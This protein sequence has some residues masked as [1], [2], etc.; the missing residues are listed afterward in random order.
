MIQL[1]HRSVLILA[2]GAAFWLFSVEVAL[3]YIFL[4]LGLLL[5]D[6]IMLPLQKQLNLERKLPHHFEIDAPSPICWKVTGLSAW[7][8]NNIT[9]ED[10]FP[11]K[12]YCMPVTSE[13]MEDTYIPSV[14]GLFHLPSAALIIKGRLGLLSRR[15]HFDSGEEIK[16]FPKARSS[17][18]L[19]ST[20]FGKTNISA[21]RT[22]K[23]DQKG[24]E[25]ES[26]RPYIHGED[27]SNIEWK[28]SAKRGALIS[29]NWEME[30]DRHVAVLIDCGRKMAEKVGDRCILDYALDAV[31][32]LSRSIQHKQDTFSL[33]AFSNKIEAS[34]PKT[35]KKNVTKQTLEAIYQL[36]PQ[37]VE[38]DYWRVLAHMMH[39]LNKRSLIIF[40]SSV[41][42]S[43][44]SL[45]LLNNLS[46]ASQKHVVLC[47]T[48]KD[49]KLTEATA[50]HE[51]V[52]RQG[53]ACHL[54]YERRRAIKQMQ[55][56]GIK[57]LEASST[58][59]IAQVIQAYLQV[60]E[61]V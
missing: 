20:A 42:D 55:M 40:F 18:Q 41:L 10:N 29:K 56:M 13:I 47:I 8:A 39:Q 52:Y 61:K 48:M 16:V 53:A 23:I 15:Y 36:T 17:Q 1:T 30:N 49:D 4:M 9:L 25:I 3:A 35:D 51:D 37:P 26:L 6:F 28:V 44:D 21:T 31:A 27:L 14:R 45:G 60:R 5:F 57:V 43:A 59:F 7:T 33:Y 58:T 24:G 32:E 50:Q 46:K 54:L 38:S 22:S 12:Q 11:N 34:L 19:L 2:L